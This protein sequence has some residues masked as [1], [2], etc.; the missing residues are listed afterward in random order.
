MSTS[1]EQMEKRLGADWGHLRRAREL[2]QSKRLELRNALSNLDTEDTSIVVSGSLARD[3][4]TE[5]SDL[6][7]TLL[8]D[9]PSD[10]G[11]YAVTTKIRDI[12]GLISAKPVGKE[13]TFGAM[14][15]SHDLVHQIGGGDDTNRNTTRRLLLLLESHVVGREDAYRNVV[16]NVLNR[17]LLE[18]RGFWRGSEHRVPRF[19]Q[20]DFARYWRTMAVDFAYKLRARSGKGWVR[21]PPR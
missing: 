11:H 8:I 10:P 9:G 15:F 6:D 17:Y 16:R 1:L 2:A 4:F 21:L 14:V 19:L 18:D 20:N 7:W 13:G 5:G 12:V 3:E